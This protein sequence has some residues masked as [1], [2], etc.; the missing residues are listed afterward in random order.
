MTGNAKYAQ[1]HKMVHDY[2]YHN[3]HDKKFGEWFGYFHRDGTL[4]QPAKGNLFKG[5]FYLP[6]QESYCKRLLE[7]YLGH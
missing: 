4:A 5:A 3:F 2:A 7:S 6:Q 1:W